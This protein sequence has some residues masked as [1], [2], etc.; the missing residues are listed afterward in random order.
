MGPR[1]G[2]V[3]SLSYLALRFEEDHEVGSDLK[4]VLNLDSTTERRDEV[5]C[6]GETEPNS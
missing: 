2:T 1:V 3:A 5:S 4:R 6:D